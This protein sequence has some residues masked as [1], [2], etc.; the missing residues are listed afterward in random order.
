MARHRGGAAPARAGRTDA[1]VS[2]RLLVASL[3][4]QPY[5]A[6]LELQRR[7]CRERVEGLRTEDLLLLV[8]HDP[9][10]TLGRGFRATSLPDG[11]AA[12]RA[13][14][15]DVVEVERGGDVTWHG[16]GQLVGYPIVHLSEHREDLHWYLRTLERALIDALRT[17][18]VRAEARPGLTGVWAAGGKVASIGVHVKRWVTLHGFALNVTT[19]P[20]AFDGMVPCGI[21]GVT[22][23]SV[24]RELGTADPRLWEAAH[25]AVTNALGRAFLRAPHDVPPASLAAAEPDAVSR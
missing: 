19:A 22:M 11:G 15:V 2:D 8:E 20:D 7:L 14:G 10:V 1:I 16:P 17:L 25:H 3:G 13:R 24:A 12:L 5:A 21:D 23:T 6:V 18:G 9:V 4:R